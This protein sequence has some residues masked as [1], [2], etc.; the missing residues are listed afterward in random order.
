VG[1][2]QP[3]YSPNGQLIVFTAPKKKHK[4]RKEYEF[5]SS[6]DAKRFYPNDECYLLSAIWHDL[7]RLTSS[8]RKPGAI[9]NVSLDSTR[10]S[11]LK[12]AK[13]KKD[14]RPIK[15]AVWEYFF[16]LYGGGPAFQ[17]YGCIIKDYFRYLLMTLLNFS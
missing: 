8:W 3:Y 6:Q 15:K 12:T 4:A 10:D 2:P 11:L 7:D 13:P 14:L 5:V 1:C 9:N 16:Q 17:W